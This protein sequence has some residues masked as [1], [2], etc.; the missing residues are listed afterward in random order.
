MLHVSS[1]PVKAS[2]GIRDEQP[3]AFTRERPIGQLLC[4][5]KNLQ[6]SHVEQILVHQR[7][8][9]GKSV[10]RGSFPC[11]AWGVRD[12]VGLLG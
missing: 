10:V 12:G 4:Q 8:H 6:P 5:L 3:A 9:G 2:E 11:V 7:Q 1:L